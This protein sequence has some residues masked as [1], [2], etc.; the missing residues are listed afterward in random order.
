MGLD[1]L[2]RRL[3]DR[4]QLLTGGQRTSLPRHRTLAA[5]V[6]WSYDLLDEHERTLFD[7][8]G[9][10]VGGFDLEAAEVVAS[11]GPLAR[12]GE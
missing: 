10:F 3:D 12:K 4:F 11:D 9:A 2:E 5:L 1:D 6:A 7:R 8:L